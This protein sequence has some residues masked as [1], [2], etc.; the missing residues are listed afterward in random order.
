MHH[1]IIWRRQIICY[2]PNNYLSGGL[3]GSPT[4]LGARLLYVSY[5]NLVMARAFVYVFFVRSWLVAGN[6]CPVS[7]I[8]VL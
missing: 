2:A 1:L 4:L 6:G 8:I 5:N 3:H 7:I